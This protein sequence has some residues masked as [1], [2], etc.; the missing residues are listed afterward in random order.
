[1]E[2]VIAFRPE[3]EQGREILDQ[4]ERQTDLQPDHVVADGTRR[5]HLDAPAADI[6]YLDPKLDRIDPEW[7]NHVTSWRVDGG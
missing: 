4:L 7:R 5:Y 6:D 3:T 1:M 2:V